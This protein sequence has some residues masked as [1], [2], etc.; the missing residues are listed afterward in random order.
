MDH[1]TKRYI[2]NEIG[3]LSMKMSA[4]LS[5]LCNE[6][7]NKGVLKPGDF[8]NM[9]DKARRTSL[10]ASGLS[11]AEFKKAVNEFITK[12]DKELQKEAKDRKDWVDLK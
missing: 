5:T 11:P 3:N 4:F 1:E 2:D 9:L 6:L 7:E 8:D 12:F 10:F